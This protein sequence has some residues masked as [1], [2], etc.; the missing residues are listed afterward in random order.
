MSYE[1]SSI[2]VFHVKS[3]HNF[4]MVS[5]IQPFPFSRQIHPQWPSCQ[6]KFRR[7]R[8]HIKSNHNLVMLTEIQSFLFHVSFIK[9]VSC[10]MGIQPFPFSYKIKKKTFVMSNK[11]FFSF[12]FSYQIQPQCCHVKGNSTISVCHV[13]SNHNMSYLR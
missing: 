8:F 9:N 6:W 10:L 2:F 5:K 3:N 7:C 13:K 12:F 1:N 11:N 4:F